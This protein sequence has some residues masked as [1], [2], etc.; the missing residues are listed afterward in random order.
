[1]AGEALTP[2]QCRGARAML[3]WSQTTLAVTAGLGRQTVVDFERGARAPYE[4]SLYA[5]RAALE[6]SGIVF[7]DADQAGVGVRFRKRTSR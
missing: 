2:A 4:S 7:I 1:M 3:N 6:K 5:M